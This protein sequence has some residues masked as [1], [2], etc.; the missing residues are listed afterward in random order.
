MLIRT[1]CKHVKMIYCHQP[2]RSSGSC[3]TIY[4]RILNYCLGMTLISALCQYPKQ[5]NRLLKISHIVDIMKNTQDSE[6]ATTTSKPAKKFKILSRNIKMPF[7]EKRTKGS[8]TQRSIR[9][10]AFQF[11][12][13]RLFS[14]GRKV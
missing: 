11:A 5:R 9:D 7:W 14:K 3:T 13:E 2:V 8:I 12:Y 10:N 1:F 6:K 4:P